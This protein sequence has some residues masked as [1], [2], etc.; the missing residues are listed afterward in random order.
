LHRPER[1]GSL[2]PPHAGGDSLHRLASLERLEHRIAL[3]AN[4]FTVTSLADSGPGSLRQAI[5]DANNS[6][7]FDVTGGI[8]PTNGLF[9]RPP[10]GNLIC[11]NQRC[12]V[13]ID[14][15]LVSFN[16]FVGMRSRMSMAGSAC[17]SATRSWATPGTA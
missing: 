11:A 17:T 4:D 14:A 12:G 13:M 16:N 9:V 6:S 1:N 10:W 3:I 5:L 8:H 7:G 2:K 15:S